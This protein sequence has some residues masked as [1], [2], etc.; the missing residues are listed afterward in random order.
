MGRPG[1]VLYV[2]DV[3]EGIY[4]GASAG[5]GGVLKMAVNYSNCVGWAKSS[6]PR[7]PFAGMT[8]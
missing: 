8:R 1:T 3:V 5:V 2:V 6:Q 4:R 7:D